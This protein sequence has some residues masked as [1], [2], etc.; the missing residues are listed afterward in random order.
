MVIKATVLKLLIYCH[1]LK[2][3]FT[4]YYESRI[5]VIKIF[6]DLISE[7]RKNILL[8]TK[9]EFCDFHCC[10]IVDLTFIYFPR[11]KVGHQQVNYQ[12]HLPAKIT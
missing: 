8:G 10:F 2:L 5:S 11:L 4:Q 1:S 9:Y 6:I 7:A 3:K 12:I